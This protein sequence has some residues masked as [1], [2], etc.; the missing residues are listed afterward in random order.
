MFTEMMIEVPVVSLA[1]NGFGGLEV[2]CWPLVPKLAG[3]NP[4]KAVGFL[5]ANKNPQ[6]AF[7]WRGSKAIGPML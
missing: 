3:S 5:R 7:L 1:E 6:H 4:A 2:E